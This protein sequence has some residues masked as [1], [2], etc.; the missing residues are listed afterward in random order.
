MRQLGCIDRVG[1]GWRHELSASI[2]SHLDAI[3]V[4]ELIID[5][6]FNAPRHK[7][8][9]VTSL[10]QYVDVIYH[11]VTLGLASTH[12]V[13]ARR[14]DQLARTLDHFQASVWSEHL[15]FVRA[16][17]YEIGHLSAPPRNEWTIEGTIQNIERAS[18]II[19]SR[20]SLE[21]I[22]T[23]IDPPGSTCTEWEW[24]GSISAEANT[25]LLLDLHNIFANAL[26][27]GYDP[28]EYV[29]SFPLDRVNL[30]HLSGG[31]WINEP[32]EYSTSDSGIRLLDDHVHD[33]PRDVFDLLEI[34]ASEVDQPLTVII[35][36]DGQYPDFQVILDQIRD[37]RAALTMGRCRRNERLHEDLHE[38]S[39]L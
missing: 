31:K 27:F 16:G 19:G 29:R 34:V 36:R 2:L 7:L 22:A 10:R 15:A 25:P 35:E 1:L 39:S 11:G 8:Q 9:A 18:T 37:A 28:V 23:L 38:R 5:D 26:N 12:A 20:P 14:V 3:D 24:V 32:A 17:G 6:Y 4:V 33:V 30:I 13:D 21:N